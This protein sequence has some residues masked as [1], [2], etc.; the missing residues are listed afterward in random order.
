MAVMHRIRIFH[1]FLALTVLAAY[2][3]P[4]QAAFMRGLVMALRPSYCLGLCGHYLERHNWGLNDF[5]PRSRIC[6]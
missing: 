5:I 3:L 2:F 4:K 1:T 6:A